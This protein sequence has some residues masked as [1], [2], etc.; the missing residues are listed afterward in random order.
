MGEV[1]MVGSDGQARRFPQGDHHFL[2]MQ[3]T[4]G[5]DVRMCLRINDLTV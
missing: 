5:G 1:D 3:I 4:Q 2:E